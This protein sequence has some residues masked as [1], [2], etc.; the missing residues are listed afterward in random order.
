V[1]PQKVTPGANPSYSYFSVTINLGSIKCSRDDFVRA[2][3]AENIECGIHYPT[4]LTKQPA[5]EA[6]M[7]PEP[8]SVSEEVS[9]NIL[10]LPMHPHLT[11]DELK[12]IVE[13]VEKV[14]SHYHK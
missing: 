14:T 13:G 9:R 6:M 11:E 3:Q 5:I 10:S 7:K 1:K 12:L 8:C 4:P 2:L